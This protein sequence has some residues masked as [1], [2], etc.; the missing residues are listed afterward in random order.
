MT[1]AIIAQKRSTDSCDS[2]Q[3]EN[4]TKSSAPRLKATQEMLELFESSLQKEF[5]RKRWD[6]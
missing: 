6:H 5:E 2:S 1:C 4:R 3:F